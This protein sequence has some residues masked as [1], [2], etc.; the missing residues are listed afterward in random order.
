MLMKWTFPP[1]EKGMDHAECPVSDVLDR[2]GDR[3]SLLVLATLSNGTMR[4]TVL[5]RA[6][7]DISQRMLAQTLRTLEQ[8][9]LVSRKVYPTIP[10]KVEYTLTLLGESLLEKL[11]PLYQWAED[12][13]GEIRAARVSYRPP[14]SA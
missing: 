10:P 3:W 13:H 11:A 5:K 9:G 8:D 14:E 1:V 6:V 12:H 4:F 7:G 2:I